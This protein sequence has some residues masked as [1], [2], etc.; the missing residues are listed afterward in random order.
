MIKAVFLDIDGT[1]I[2]FKTHEIS[3]RSR[4]AMKKARENGVRLFISTGRH[5][6]EAERVLTGLDF[7]GYVTLNGQYCYTDDE[8]IRRFPIERADIAALVDFLADRRFPC[9]FVEEEELYINFVNEDVLAVCREVQ[10]GSPKIM[11]IRRALEND[12]FQLLPYMARE[13]EGPLMRALPNCVSTRW[14]PLFSD[15]VP[16]SGDKSVGIERFMDYYG[17]FPDEI[18]AIGDGEND[19]GMIRLA[20]AGVAMGN[21]GD[22]VKEAADFVTASVDE[23]GVYK[24]FLEYGLI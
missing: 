1:L 19:L 4:E 16:A 20:K 18:M 9:L 22:L 11:D 21:A 7:D 2:S 17:I 6:S 23:D 10:L 13:D 12:V 5:R 14:H 15:I 8:I 24:A 3:S